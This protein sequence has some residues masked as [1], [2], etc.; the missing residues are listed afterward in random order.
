MPGSLSEKT[1]SISQFE[2]HLLCDISVLLSPEELWSG[3]TAG[4]ILAKGPEKRSLPVL[5]GVTPGSHGGPARGSLY[6]PSGF[7]LD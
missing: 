6:S 4:P 1:P 2:L 7:V 3:N 5:A